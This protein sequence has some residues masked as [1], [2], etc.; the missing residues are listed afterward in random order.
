MAETRPE[1]RS[2]EHGTFRSVLLDLDKTVHLPDEY[3]VVGHP[4]N[5]DIPRTTVRSILVRV[6]Q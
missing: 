3:L 6:A 2:T 1:I 5:L 4:A